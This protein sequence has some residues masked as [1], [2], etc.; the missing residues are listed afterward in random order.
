MREI[1]FVIEKDTTVLSFLKGEQH[2]SA[3]LIK[4][5]KKEEN[6]I[7]VNGKRART[8]DKIFKGDTLLVTLPGGESE[9]QAVDIPIRVVY[10]DEDVM[11]VDKQPFL[12]CHPTRNHQRDTLANAVAYYLKAKGKECTFRIINRLDRD[13]SGLAL[14]ALNRFAAAR[15][16]GEAEKTYFA[17]VTGVIEKD[18]IIDLPIARPDPLNIKRCV[19]EDGQRAVTRYEVLK[20][21]DDSTL[22]KIKL[23][24]GR[25]HQIRVHFSHLGHALVGDTM[26]G[27]RSNK[28]DRQCLHCGEIAFLQPVTG[29][30]I[31]LFSAPDFPC[32]YNFSKFTKN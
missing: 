1:K 16:G 19:A 23:E 14:I 30:R 21:Y 20:T 17:L 9:V 29:K 22:L 26:Y 10:E 11:V 2:F 6:G 27:E 3:R 13:T 24:T 5:L 8:V 25:T 31:S 4:S 7:L 32:E 12:V 28:I 18:G 15:L